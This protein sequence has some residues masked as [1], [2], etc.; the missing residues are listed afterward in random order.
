[1]HLIAEKDMEIKAETGWCLDDFMLS[2]KVK[3]RADT[4][5]KSMFR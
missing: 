4:L 1:M 5:F 3:S 2:W